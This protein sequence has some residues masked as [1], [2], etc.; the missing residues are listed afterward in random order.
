MSEKILKQYY[1]YIISNSD[2]VELEKLRFMLKKT[3]KQHGVE[4]IIYFLSCVAE[5][6]F[7]NNL[8]LEEFNE[9]AIVCGILGV[10]FY[11]F[12]RSLKQYATNEQLSK[13]IKL[14]LK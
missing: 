4:A 13:K 2:K 5:M 12:L 3:S 11:G 6:I 8:S 10:S 9:F 14:L 1:T 7:A